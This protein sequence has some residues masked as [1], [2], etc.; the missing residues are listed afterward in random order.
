[1]ILLPYQLHRYHITP[2]NKTAHHDMV[3]ERAYAIWKQ[4]NSFNSNDLIR[5]FI[6]TWVKA[7]PFKPFIDIH[8]YIHTCI[9]AYRYP[10]IIQSASENVHGIGKHVKHNSVHKDNFLQI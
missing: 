8:I 7:L 6:Y 5:V 9:Y 1:M 3:E 2:R 4:V 10:H